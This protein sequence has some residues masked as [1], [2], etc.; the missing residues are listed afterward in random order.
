MVPHEKTVILWNNEVR[1]MITNANMP[2]NGMPG[3]FMKNRR[4]S[5]KILPLTRIARIFGQQTLTLEGGDNLDTDSRFR[6]GK[7]GSDVRVVQ[8]R[9]VLFGMG[10]LKTMAPMV[11]AD[12]LL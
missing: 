3:G 6:P 2:G 5:L 8:C 7:N 4:S 12:A 10:F 11:N 9:P 1:H